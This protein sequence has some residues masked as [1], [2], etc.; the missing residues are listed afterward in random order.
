MKINITKTRRLAICVVLPLA[1]VFAAC[2]GIPV[3]IERVPVYTPA[4][5]SYQPANDGGTA[6][7]NAPPASNNNEA[8]EHVS[9][10]HTDYAE[11][12][13]TTEADEYE[14]SND[15]VVPN[16]TAIYGTFALQHNFSG[17]TITFSQGSRFNANLS[18]ND[19][20]LDFS[21]PGN[22]NVSGVYVINDVVQTV[23][24]NVLEDD[25]LNLAVG[26]MDTLLEHVLDEMLDGASD[27][28]DDLLSALLPEI[29]GIVEGMLDE[30]VAEISAM[31][32]GLV[33]R[34]NNNFDRLYSV[35]DENMVFDRQ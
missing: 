5:H 24:L 16:F 26:L 27:E 14:Q 10:E 30:I 9:D 28:D 19:L 4:V 31:F 3:E 23:T 17:L 20:D 32:D 6:E 22:I 34:Y 18:L 1:F 35:D 33:L 15:A 29:I 12:V 2:G 11:S 25:I 7:H 21:I 8:S 13:A